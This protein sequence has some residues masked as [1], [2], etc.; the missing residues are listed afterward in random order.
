MEINDLADRLTH[1]ES[2]SQKRFEQLHHAIKEGKSMSETARVNNVFETP[3]GG[4]GGGYGGAGGAA[5]LGG[6]GGAAIGALLGSALGGNGGLFG[7]RNGGEGCVTPANLSAQLAGVVDTQM[8]TAV[9]QGLGDLKGAVPLAEAQ[10]QLAIAGA[11][12]EVR[13]HLGN[14]ENTLVQG[15]TAINKNVSDAISASLASQNNLN[16]NILTQGSATRDAVNAMGVANLTATA[17]ST[18]EILAAINDQN[19]ANL[20]R[21]LAVA[22]SALL[23]RNASL[24]ARETEINITNTNTATA[25]QLQTQSMQQQQFQILANLAAGITNLA[26]DV[27]AVRQTQSTVNFGTMTGNS[28][29]A[30]ATNNRV[31]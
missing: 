21:Q 20:Q 2:A 1:H 31:S 12:G 8:N 26:N 24:R 5:G 6:A 28:Q 29:A 16:V 7:N 14:V 30:Q 22:E 3:M 4:W 23:E 10:T 17:N 15:Q 13:S 18:K 27:Q 25:Q 9:L 19:T 11:V